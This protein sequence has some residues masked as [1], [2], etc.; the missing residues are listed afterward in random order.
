M[1][2]IAAT[3]PSLDTLHTSS[4]LSY[5]HGGYEK[6]L[7][8]VLKPIRMQAI[9]WDQIS[10]TSSRDP[11]LIGQLCIVT[12][13]CNAQGVV[14][15]IYSGQ[16]EASKPERSVGHPQGKNEGAFCRPGGCDATDL[17]CPR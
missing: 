14:Q 5:G 4:G 7:S 11:R 8:E 17:E 3:A 2:L 9:R 16:Q 6:I 15:R 12:L 1:L 13:F 10:T